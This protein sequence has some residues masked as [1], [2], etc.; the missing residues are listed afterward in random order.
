MLGVLKKLLV[1]QLVKKFQ[2]FIQPEGSSPCSKQPYTY[3]D[4]LSYAGSHWFKSPT[5]HQLPLMTIF[6]PF[7]S[8]L[9]R[10]TWC[11]LK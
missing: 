2:H 3:G 7:L 10:I 1:P 6:V 9:S 11:Y 8:P 4:I 5:Q